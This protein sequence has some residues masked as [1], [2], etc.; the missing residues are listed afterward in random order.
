MKPIIANKTTEKTAFTLR[1]IFQEK[2]ISSFFHFKHMTDMSQNF[3]IMMTSLYTKAEPYWR[4]FDFED[5]LN[6]HP[7][8]IKPFNFM[9]L[10]MW[11]AGM[12]DMQMWVAAV[13]LKA[14][15]IY[16]QVLLFL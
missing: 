16:S 9:H 3:I 8:F 2:V 1:L 7:L 6:L 5:T 13:K 4:H 14:G 15:I 10:S 12:T 11:K